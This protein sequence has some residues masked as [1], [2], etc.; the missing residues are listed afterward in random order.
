VGT[1]KILSGNLTELKG[2]IKSLFASGQQ[3]ELQAGLAYLLAVGSPDFSPRLLLSNP[4]DKKV[5]SR[6]IVI[7]TK[8]NQISRIDFTPSETGQF[9]FVV[10]SAQPGQTGA[11][12]LR[13]QAYKLAE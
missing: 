7:N 1:P 5:L 11:Y 4:M 3:I 2:A 6:G 10:P 12:T 9:L 13:V 8:K